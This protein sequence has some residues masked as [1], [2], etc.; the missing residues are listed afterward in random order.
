[1][2]RWSGASKAPTV[3]RRLCRHGCGA[4]VDAFT[5]AEIG[6]RRQLCTEPPPITQDLSGAARECRLWEYGGPN[7]GWYLLYRGQRRWR[8]LRLAHQ[9]ENPSAST[10]AS[11]S[12]EERT[13]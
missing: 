8:E 4:E 9:C 11:A 6:L 7:V 2:S 3:T 10:R 1:M 5:D 12:T 13:A